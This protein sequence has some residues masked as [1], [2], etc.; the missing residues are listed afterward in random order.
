MKY[1]QNIL[2]PLSRGIPTSYGS[3]QDVILGRVKSNSSFARPFFV[4]A[5]VTPRNTRLAGSKHITYLWLL[6]SYKYSVIVIHHSWLSTKIRLVTGMQITCVTNG[7]SLLNTV[8]KSKYSH[9]FIPVCCSVAFNSTTD[10]INYHI[11]IW[12]FHQQKQFQ[13]GFTSGTRLVVKI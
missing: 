4:M 5:H 11:R 1:S 7:L 13:R 9:E 10:Y 8:N 2:Y 6:T 12:L 3:S